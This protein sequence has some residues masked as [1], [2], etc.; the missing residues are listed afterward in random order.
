MFTK[1]NSFFNDSNS[2][3]HENQE[4]RPT[5]PMIGPHFFKRGEGKVEITINRSIPALENQNALRAQAPSFSNP[6]LTKI[7]AITETKAASKSEASEKSESIESESSCQKKEEMSEVFKYSSSASTDSCSNT[8]LPTNTQSIDPIKKVEN[9]LKK[10][11][12]WERKQGL[13]K[14]K[15]NRFK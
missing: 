7:N 13:K 10:N 4:L 15:K 6:Y 1:L 5:Q 3:N 8:T 12:K 14:S 11:E 2:Q 9:W